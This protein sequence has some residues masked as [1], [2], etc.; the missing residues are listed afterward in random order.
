[1]QQLQPE[2]Q[3]LQ[4]NCTTCGQQKTFIQENNRYYCYQCQKYE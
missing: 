2:I 3:P 1:M 4:G